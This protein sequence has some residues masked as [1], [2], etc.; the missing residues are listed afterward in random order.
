MQG[1]E[2]QPLEVCDAILQSEL[3]CLYVGL[4]RAREHVWF[5]DSTDKGDAFEVRVFL[6]PRL[7]YERF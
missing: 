5:W 7:K 3:K 1:G 4:T 6:L 2:V